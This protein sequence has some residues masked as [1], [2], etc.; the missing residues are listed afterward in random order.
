MSVEISRRG[1]LRGLALFAAARPV[2]SYA[3]ARG[4]G[5]PKVAFGV[6]SDVHICCLPYMKRFIQ[7][8]A[9]YARMRDPELLEKAFAY[10]RDGGAD[11]VAIAGDIAD[12]GLVGQLQLVADTWNKVF[13]SGKGKDGRSVTRLFALGNHDF[14]GW[15]YA[16]AKEAR[17]EWPMPK[18]EILAADMKGNWKKIFGEKYEP[19]WMKSVKGYRFVGAHWESAKGIH[20]L[21]PW[22]EKHAA[23][24]AGEKPFFYFQHAQP[25]NTCLGNW[26]WGHDDGC[27]TK[28]LAKFPNAVA[29]SGHSHKP[30]TSEL[31]VWQGA[32]TSIGTA[33]L[34]SMGHPVGRDNAS[35]ALDLNP[36]GL[37]RGDGTRRKQ[38]TIAAHGQF[39]RVYDEFIEIERIE[40]VSGRKLGPNLVIPLPATKA[41][42]FLFAT[43]AEKATSP[44]P[45]PDGAKVEVTRGKA[46][47]RGEP[48]PQ[49]VFIVTFPQTRRVA[50]ASRTADYEITVETTEMDVTEIRLTRYVTSPN[51]FYP[52][53]TKKGPVKFILPAFL[54]PKGLSVR[55]GVCARETFGKT[56]TPIW[57]SSILA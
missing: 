29:F 53:G 43:Q 56:N 37:M 31:N 49:D 32:F 7:D 30:L 34:F 24:L 11:G 57:S 45:F 4:A 23:E 6:L 5:E 20:A 50:G 12:W 52:E 35:G 48:K 22:A 33:S 2:A 26:I 15:H 3:V 42:P 25:K 14:H 10:F 1:F 39:V 8:P 13:P 47:L 41:K 40:F 27:A 44:A 46:P 38:K 17:G 51:D 54:V 18:E 21:A 28:V 16:Y 9:H 19:I 55:F 36:R